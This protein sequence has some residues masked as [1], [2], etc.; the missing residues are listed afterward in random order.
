MKCASPEVVG[1]AIA[2]LK[3]H[4]AHVKDN[5][6]DADGW[7]RSYFVPPAVVEERSAQ[8]VHK[9]SCAG[10][11]RKE[12]ANEKFKKCSACFSPAYWYPP[13]FSPLA[14]PTMSIPPLL[15]TGEDEHASTL[16]VDDSNAV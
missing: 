4:A 12:T 10:C 15:H 6:T 14:H 3:Q 7:T 11:G 2:Q 8:W 1:Y 13:S 16:G 9:T 5:E